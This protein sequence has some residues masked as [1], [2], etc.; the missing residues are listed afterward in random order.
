MKRI[1]LVTALAVV[2]LQFGL[3][4]ATGP[5]DGQY[6]GGAPAMGRM[7]CPASQVTLSITD[8]KVAGTILSDKYTFPISGTVAADG[9][10]TGKWGVYPFT[11][12]ITGAHI[13]GS[14]VSK[15]C[16]GA[17]PISMDKTG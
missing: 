12:K 5:F 15:E 16:N 2:A 14:F 6:K 7:G 10:V 8:G 13:A 4:G 9:T 3:A 11:A 1:A 17:R